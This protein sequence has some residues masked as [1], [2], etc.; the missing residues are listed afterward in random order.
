MASLDDLS[1]VELRRRLADDEG[2]PDEQVMAAIAVKQGVPKQELADWFDVSEDTIDDWIGRTVSDAEHAAGSES[3]G[4]TGRRTEPEPLDAQY[5]SRV[6][7]LDYQVL[8]D[9]G[10][11][12]DD[13]DLFE[14][15]AEA[16][17]DGD[18]HGTIWVSGDESILDAAESEGHD[19][20]FSC[21][22]GACAN[23][24]AVCKEGAIHMPTNQI[25]P[26]EAITERN[27]RLTCIGRPASTDIKLVYGAK[28]L[29]YLEDILLPPQE[30]R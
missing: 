17:L 28:Q 18:Q 29:D 30:S 10:W 26:T 16:D 19:W 6:E 25:L 27:V 14:K 13:E 15:A 7:F 8:S 21:R 12:L 20:P 11:D 23:C 24:A 5:D 1:I 9:R 2:G 3:A 4:T 22:A